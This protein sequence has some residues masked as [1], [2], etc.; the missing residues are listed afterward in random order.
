MGKV[1]SIR[2]ILGA[3]GPVAKGLAGYEVRAEQ[4][5]MAG[6][7]A[8]A[9]DEG[10]HLLVEAGTGVGKTFA[11]LVP[12]IELAVRK[13]AKV[14]VSTKTIALQEQIMHK[15]IPFLRRV[16]PWDFSA[17]LVKGRSNY[18]SIRRLGRVS[19]RQDSLFAGSERA[20]LWKVEDWAKTTGDGSLSDMEAPPAPSP[21]DD[22]PAALIP[23]DT[24][25]NHRAA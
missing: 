2:D 12:A 14:V 22:V 6:A 3:D 20:A 24:R 9:F 8:K 23:F 25:P 11:Y 7:V 10:S 15:D 17:V 13:R 21:E 4:L 5:E 19:Q 16:L 1:V 18:L